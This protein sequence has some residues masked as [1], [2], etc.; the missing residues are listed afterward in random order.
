VAHKT[1]RLVQRGNGNDYS[2]LSLLPV[3]IRIQGGE[4]RCE[5]LW[6]NAARCFG[7]RPSMKRTERLFLWKQLV[8]FHHLTE[9]I[10]NGCP[11]RIVG[12]T[13]HQHLVFAPPE[14]NYHRCFTS[15]AS[16]VLSLFSM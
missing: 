16:A 13:R 9:I 1:A 6:M 7:Y 14:E 5:T 11:I 10:V 3:R 4:G 15:A 2:A 8:G 12:E